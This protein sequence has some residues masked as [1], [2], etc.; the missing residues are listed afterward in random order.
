MELSSDNSTREEYYNKRKKHWAAQEATVKAV[1]GGSEDPHLP[2]IKCS[3]EL[4]FGLISTNNLKP[5]KALDCA[6]GIG[7]VTQLVL[8]NYFEEIDLIEQ[9]EKFILK[10]KEILGKNPKV[11]NF[12]SSSIQDFNFDNKK[13]FYDLIWVQWCLEN[14]EDCDLQSFLK[15]CYIALKDDG[16]MIVKENIYVEDSEE[17][18]EEKKRN[19]YSIEDFSNQREDYKY[20]DLFI[21]N[22]FIIYRHFPNPNWPEALMPL[23][24]YVL[25]KNTK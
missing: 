3:N 19:A 12:Y 1:V 6:A 21:N 7:R 2:D 20:V 25:K 14:I 15:K 22:G 23:I 11:K 9:D 10:A 17:D 18:E 8:T 4:L 24:V 16:L 13:N 5:G